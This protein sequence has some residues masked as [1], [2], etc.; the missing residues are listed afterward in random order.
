[1]F[2]YASLFAGTVLK[3][4]GP[5]NIY[6]S[7]DMDCREAY[8][9]E[10]FLRQRAPRVPGA[11]MKGESARCCAALRAPSRKITRKTGDSPTLAPPN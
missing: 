5:A 4:I 11:P 10:R 9:R 7:I 8:S 2:P 1:M 6:W 3:T